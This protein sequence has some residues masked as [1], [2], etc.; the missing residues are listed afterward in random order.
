VV[1]R[2]VGG[3]SRVGNAHAHARV[4][5][6]SAPRSPDLARVLLR[7]RQGWRPC[8]VLWLAEEVAPREEAEL[9]CEWNKGKCGPQLGLQVRLGWRRRLALGGRKGS[10]QHLL[11]GEHSPQLP[12]LQVRS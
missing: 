1:F 3:G 6:P 4:A 9:L 7:S 10:G 5:Q 2:G 11:C 8:Q 12:W